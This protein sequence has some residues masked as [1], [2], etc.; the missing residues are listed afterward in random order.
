MLGMNCLNM[1]HPTGIKF[2]FDQN[3]S[4]IFSVMQVLLSGS[5]PNAKLINDA[6]YHTISSLKDALEKLNALK[7]GTWIPKCEFNG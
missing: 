3:D 6:L 5:F 4:C 2:Y 1:K 7:A